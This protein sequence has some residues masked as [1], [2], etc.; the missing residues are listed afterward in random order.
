MTRGHAA[1]FIGV[2]VAAT[3]L[4]GCGPSSPNR[5]G[6][7]DPGVHAV[8]GYWVTEEHRCDAA[9]LSG[10]SDGVQEAIAALDA[11]EPDAV[12]TGASSAGYPSMRGNG[13]NEISFT[14]GGWQKPT[15][16]ILDLADGSRRTFGMNCGPEWSTDGTPTGRVACH[17]AELDMW[18]VSRS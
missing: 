16:V 11:T 12:V 5:D 13:P 9:D 4:T 8:D 1:R 10:C 3:L 2:V 6:W 18:R 17:V 7:W 15:F 14:F